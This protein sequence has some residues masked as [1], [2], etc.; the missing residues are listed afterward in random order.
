MSRLLCG[1]PSKQWTGCKL[2]DRPREQS[3]V[4]RICVTLYVDL[5]FVGNICCFWSDGRS[6]L[7]GRSVVRSSCPLGFLLSRGSRISAVGLLFQAPRTIR[8]TQHTIT[9]RAHHTT[10]HHKQM[11]GN[12]FSPIA[13]PSIYL[14][15]LV[16][17]QSYPASSH[18]KA[19]GAT[20][21]CEMQIIPLLLRYIS[22]AA[23]VVCAVRLD[24]YMIQRSTDITYE[25]GCSTYGMYTEKKMW[26]SQPTNIR[27]PL[28]APASHLLRG[29]H[30]V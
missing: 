11:P 16:R 8:H 22:S 3:K 24:A 28:P 27:P 19:N 15:V 17:I 9:I 20:R 5:V 1:A 23:A 21:P 25:Y 4:I 30:P 2:S 14:L 7:V 26:K 18:Q 12:I 6:L 10:T 13:C 29:S